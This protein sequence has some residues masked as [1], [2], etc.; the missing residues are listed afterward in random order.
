LKKMI[1]KNKLPHFYQKGDDMKTT[2]TKACCAL[3]TLLMMTSAEA[4]A[5]SSGAGGGFV[6]PGPA[7]IGAAQVKE[8]RDDANVSLRGNVIQHLG[9]DD[10][11]FRDST[12]TVQVEIDHDKW[13]GLKVSPEDVVTL[14][15]EVD[16]DFFSTK[17]DV[18]RV[19]KE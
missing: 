5:A 15:G 14:H 18:D 6:G 7:V 12:G 9:G 8:M 13:G 10:Y 11:L 16:K 19:A 1:I 17:V 2:K 4:A 3:L